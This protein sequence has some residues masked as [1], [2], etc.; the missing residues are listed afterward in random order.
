LINGAALTADQLMICW[1]SR[2]AAAQQVTAVR[3]AGHPAAG[4][5]APRYHLELLVLAESLDFQRR[6]FVYPSVAA[7]VTWEDVICRPISHGQRNRAL[8]RAQDSTRIWN[9]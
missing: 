7:A 9:G 4:R 2:S 1:R 8:R 5:A 6:W 3:T